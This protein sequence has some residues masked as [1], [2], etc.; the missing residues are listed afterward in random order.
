MG[1][2]WGVGWAVI[3]LDL[4]LGEENPYLKDTHSPPTTVSKDSQPIEKNIQE[5]HEET[6]YS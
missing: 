3:V 4:F 1:W 2:G 5:K 6:H